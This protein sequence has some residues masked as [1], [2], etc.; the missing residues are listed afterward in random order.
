M[1]KVS[2][3]TSVPLHVIYTTSP[4]QMN[5]QPAPAH[6]AHWV[7]AT[8]RQPVN[9]RSILFYK[10][11]LSNAVYLLGSEYLPADTFCDL[12]SLLFSRIAMQNIRPD[13]QEAATKLC[14]YWQQMKEKV[15]LRQYRWPMTFAGIQR[16]SGFIATHFPFPAFFRVACGQLR[17]EEQG[18]YFGPNGRRIL[19]FVNM[20][21]DVGIDPAGMAQHTASDGQVYTIVPRD[22]TSI[23]PLT[24]NGIK[25]E[26]A[27]NNPGH[28]VPYH[29]QNKE[30]FFIM[31]FEPMEGEPYY[32]MAL[33]WGDQSVEI[34]EALLSLYF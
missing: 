8:I 22:I 2:H 14:L 26:Q 13:R 15:Q 19:H 27:E 6:D 4:H 30:T 5:Q 29:V 21:R 34:K 12:Q 33:V 16:L 9:R 10:V 3:S 20:D 31:T 17:H 7:T 32:M 1:A 11:N 23:R 24:V 28:Q 18:L 25:Q